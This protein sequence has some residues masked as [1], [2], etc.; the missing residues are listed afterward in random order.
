VNSSFC[1]VEAGV[2]RWTGIALKWKRTVIIP[3]REINEFGQ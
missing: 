3:L 2:L 1:T